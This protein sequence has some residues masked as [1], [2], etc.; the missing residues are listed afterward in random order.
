MISGNLEFSEV[1]TSEAIAY[2]NNS[3]LAAGWR[4]GNPGKKLMLE[5]SIGL[6]YQTVYWSVD[7]SFSDVNPNVLSNAWVSRIEMAFLIRL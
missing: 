4:L 5:S 1:E 3:G 2:T 6:A 7:S